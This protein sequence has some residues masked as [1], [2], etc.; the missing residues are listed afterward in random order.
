MDTHKIGHPIQAIITVL[1]CLRMEM[2]DAKKVNMY[3][4]MSQIT[5][6]NG[7]VIGES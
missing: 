1:Y 3:Y 4:T 5:L 6:V 7:S 2:V